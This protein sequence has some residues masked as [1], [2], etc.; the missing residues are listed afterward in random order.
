[1]I[2]T[3]VKLHILFELFT[4]AEDKKLLVICLPKSDRTAGSC[5]KSLL[6]GQ[7]EADPWTW[8]Q[9]QQKLTL[10]RYQI[11]VGCCCHSRFMKQIEH[12]LI[13]MGSFY[14]FITSDKFINL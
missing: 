6:D 12:K 1:M 14:L 2:L 5:W 7:Y 13:L 3:K 4:L 10:E 9:M 11:E 8:D